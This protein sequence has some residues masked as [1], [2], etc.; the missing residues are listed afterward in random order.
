MIQDI[1]PKKF[2][3]EFEVENIGADSKVILFEG[4][5]VLIKKT[6]TDELVLP[7][8][9]EIKK[10]KEDI[11]QKD[12]QYIF[13][14]DSEKFFLQKPTAY[15][16]IAAFGEYTYENISIMR[17]MVS[18][19]IC[20]AVM[21]AFHLYVWYNDNK[22][23][24]RC[25]HKTEHSMKERMLHCSECNNAIYPKI[26]PAVIV[27]LVHGDRIL[28]SKY[29]DREYKKYALLAGFNE[30]GETAE[31]TVMREV[32]EE[33][34]LRVKRMKYYKSQPWGFD[35]NLLLGYFAELDGSED[36]SMD[37]EELAVAEWFDRPD[38]PYHN[39]GISLTTEMIGFF[40]DEEKFK[41]WYHS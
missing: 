30:F 32:F 31:E 17:Q 1:S 18:K 2:A 4:R 36:I 11:S 41:K 28:M 29:A 3:N 8:Y 9:A 14:I 15:T 35:S 10:E 20:F 22:F 27:G 26:A 12:Y 5:T 13:S 6:E 38:I 34:G 16:E 24:G 23:C 37:T 39:D 25:G 21:N 7:T 19:E 40:E 33:V